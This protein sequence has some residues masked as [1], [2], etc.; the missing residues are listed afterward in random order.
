MERWI[1]G[2]LKIE[3]ANKQM[4]VLTTIRERFQKEKPFKSLTIAACLHITSET[5]T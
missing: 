1:F 3:W 2:R 4:S 5:A